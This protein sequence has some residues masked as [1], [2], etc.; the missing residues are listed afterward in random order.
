MAP[1]YLFVD[2][3]IVDTFLEKMKNKILEMTDNDPSKS[4]DYGR[5][6]NEFHANRMK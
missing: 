4:V 3:S 6:V 5:L 2:E 1:D